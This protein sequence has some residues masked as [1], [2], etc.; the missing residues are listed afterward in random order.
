MY[1]KIKN[2]KQ[3]YMFH[4]ILGHPAYMCRRNEDNEIVCECGATINHGDYY[5]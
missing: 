5:V 1:W 2:P 3:W 4:A